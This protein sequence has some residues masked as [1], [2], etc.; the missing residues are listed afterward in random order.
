VLLQPLLRLA[1]AFAFAFIGLAAVALPAHAAPVGSVDGGPCITFDNHG[2]RYIAFGRTGV[3][4]PGVYL[5]TNRSGSWR[6]S[7]HPVAVGE[8]CASILVDAVGHIHLLAVRAEPPSDPVTFSELRY[9]TNKSGAWRSSLVR[10]GEIGMASVAIDR[11][12]RASVA[13]S[14]EDGMF[15]FQRSPSGGWTIRYDTTG[16]FS[17]LRTDRTGAVFMLISDAARDHIVRTANRSGI[18]RTSTT[19][20]PFPYAEVLDLAIDSVGRRFAA[21]YD[22]ASGTVTVYRDD[23]T[24]WPRID[25]TRA[26]PDRDLLDVEAE[27]SGDLHVMLGFERGGGALGIVDQ[28]HHGGAWQTQLIG[29]VTDLYADLAVDRSGRVGAAFTR[30]GVVWSYWNDW[31]G[32]PHRFAISSL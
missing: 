16:P 17:H 19:P 18:W 10:I 3:T 12:G 6:I 2:Y 7:P 1:R 30:D 5:A 29:F 15:L 22:A 14:D 21:S 31:K 20:L 8:R 32:A 27:P 28:N 23:G 26:H 24:S 4:E 25:R 9:A 11:L 13:T